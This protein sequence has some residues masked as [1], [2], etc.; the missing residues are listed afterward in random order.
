MNLR[1]L[2]L[3]RYVIKVYAIR[4]VLE[5]TSF[6]MNPRYILK[7]STNF[8]LG[9]ILLS[10]LGL[11][12]WSI[13]EVLHWNILPQFIQVYAELLIIV[14]SILVGLT[15]FTSLICLVAV[16]GE[17]AGQRAGYESLSITRRFKKR[18][19]IFIVGS[20]AMVV[21]FYGINNI[22]QVRLKQ[23]SDERTRQHEL[24]VKERYTK[25]CLA[26]DS[27]LIIQVE[28]TEHLLVELLTDSSARHKQE[29]VELI[30]S[31]SMS[32]PFQPKIEL[33]RHGR[34]PY[35]YEILTATQ[36]N[37]STLNVNRLLS[38]PSH[39]EEDFV[40]ELMLYGETQKQLPEGPLFFKGDRPHGWCLISQGGKRVG[41]IMARSTTSDY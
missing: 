41:I 19:V 36:H 18:M 1:I 38:M 15:M 29:L 8:T 23:L 4:L 30:Q 32:L 27:G 21:L 17:W 28:R 37:D 13:D 6:Q 14:V 35:R 12:L 20:L 9:L 39:E 31:L 10:G 26:I 5:S 34:S 11:I 2:I 33:L 3:F 16:I 40:R 7:V 24:E 22:R 25:A